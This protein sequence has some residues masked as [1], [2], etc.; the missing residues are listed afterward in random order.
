MAD[1]T[2][3]RLTRLLG[4][5]HYL[6]I[7]GATPFT[8]LADHFGVSE[9]QVRADVETLWV[10]GLPGHQYDDLIDFDGFLFDQGIADL[11]NS[12]GVSQVSF[13]AREAAALMGA[14]SALS[15]AGA[16]PAASAS[17][18]EKL[19]GAVGGVSVDVSAS[20]PVRDEVRSVLEAGMVT[21][22]AVILDYVDAQDR[23]TERTVEPHRL[24]VIDGAAYLECWCRRA[25][26]HRTLRLDRIASAVPTTS[27]VTHPPVD[28]HGFSLTQRYAATV[29]L[30]RAARWAVE[31]LPGVTIMADGD[32]TVTATFGVANPGWT[33]GRLLAIA[34]HLVS[35]EPAAL[36]T[37]LADRAR[38]VLAAQG[39]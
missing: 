21:G 3:G 7:H 22:T 18:M 13:S 17:V 24:V 34:P 16:A 5:V 33:A 27:E 15:A 1:R 31:D 38:G 20:S 26:D 2:L 23:R 4:I 35:V 32:E 10:S 39:D 30:E 19:R 9:R 36:R 28:T 6:E 37:A 8:E 25:E 29:T 11:T 14:L 12:Q